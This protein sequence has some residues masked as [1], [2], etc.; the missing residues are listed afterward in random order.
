MQL[1]ISLL[2]HCGYPRF[3]FVQRTKTI[4][5]LRILIQ[6][7]KPEINF[8][9]NG[10]TDFDWE[11]DSLINEKEWNDGSLREYTD[12]LALAEYNLNVE[13]FQNGSHS[14]LKFLK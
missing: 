1:T 8:S 2:K 3:T 11:L 13:S 6:K 12:D 10:K 7:F 5:N 14:A 9:P 4:T